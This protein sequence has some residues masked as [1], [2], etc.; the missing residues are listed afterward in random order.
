M[1]LDDYMIVL[2]KINSFTSS[3]IST[4]A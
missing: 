1:F 3:S 2:P 4:W